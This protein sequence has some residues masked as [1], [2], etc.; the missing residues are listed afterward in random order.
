MRLLYLIGR[1]DN[2]IHIGLADN[3][4]AFHLDVKEQSEALWIFYCQHVYAEF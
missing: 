4:K 1:Y 3:A 2:V